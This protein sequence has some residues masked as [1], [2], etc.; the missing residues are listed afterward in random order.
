[1]TN[2]IIFSL[3]TGSLDP[4]YLG[5]FG[6]ARRARE[7][8]KQRVPQL[9]SAQVVQEENTPF[10][11]AAQLSAPLLSLGGA[12]QL[13]DAARF[14]PPWITGA[15]HEDTLALP[16]AS[17]ASELFRR[18]LQA[19]PQA[20]TLEVLDIVAKLNGSSLVVLSQSPEVVEVVI[21]PDA[22]PLE[23]PPRGRAQKALPPASGITVEE[24]LRTRRAA[25]PAESVR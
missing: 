5:A 24:F 23:L 11:S 19:D 22:W 9:P 4:K 17:D 1:M 8:A 20:T 10:A 16:E 6:G 21:E 14:A 25:Q 15:S 3:F 12:P 18:D 13:G 7:V 2:S